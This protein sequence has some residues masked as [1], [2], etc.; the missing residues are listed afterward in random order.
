MVITSLA[1]FEAGAP[2][3]IPSEQ[4]RM[5][6]YAKNA[7]LYDGKHGQVWPDL[8]PFGINHSAKESSFNVEDYIDRNYV[9]MTIN[10]YKRA[11]TVFA[12]LL[13]GE[14]FQVT[15]DKQ[16]AADRLIADNALVLKA[17][18]IA[19]SMVRNGTGIFK[20]RFDKRGY[21]DV[22]N[23]RIWFPVVSPDSTEFVAHVLAWSFKEGS[24]EFVRAEIHEKGTITNKLFLVEGG[25][26]KDALLT[27]FERYSKIPPVIKTGVDGFLVVP[28]Q[29]LLGSDGVYG[30]DDY[31]DMNDLVKELEKRLIQNSRVLTKHADP[32]ISGPA[33]KIDVDPYSGEAVVVGGGQY[34]GYNQGEPQP[35]YMVWNAQLPAVFQQIDQII[36]RLYMV[37]E[38]SP[39]ALGELKQGLAESGSALKRLMMATLAKVN[40]LRLRLDPG[41]REILRVT[42]ALEVL[43]RGAG[44]AQLGNI[45]I[46][47]QDGLP[48]DEKEETLL[49]V[50]KK[51]VGLT[52]VTS[53]L[54]R[55]EP[56]M[57]DAARQ[58]EAA[59]I[60]K[61]NPPKQWPY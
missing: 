29:N 6:R 19:M 7:L 31:S 14:P 50:E 36:E 55:L 45:R 51:K 17:H 61:E 53:S 43:G 5:D 1:A 60:L 26:L 41:T 16:E 22:I 13:C 28:V 10:F 48:R 56:E 44:A 39:A 9:E 11:T 57:D 15:A 58:V 54:K 59:S 25:K 33:S 47:W 35:A 12:D 21:I 8:N 32:S 38:L 34:Y 20:A 40:R 37:S 18:E 52:T 2:W 46:K 49:E 3:P 23:P 27:R 4:A 24:E 42:A 30:M